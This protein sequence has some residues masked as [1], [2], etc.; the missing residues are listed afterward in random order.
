MTL[1]ED[2]PVD[3]SDRGRRPESSITAEVVSRSRGG[4]VALV[5]VLAVLTTVVAAV[6]LLGQADPAT[7]RATDDD[8]HTDH[9]HTE[10]AADELTSYHSSVEPPLPTAAPA[11]GFDPEVSVANHDG[12][13]VASVVDGVLMFTVAGGTV[14]QPGIEV[15]PGFEVR[16]LSNRGDRAALLRVETDSAGTVTG[17]AVMVAGRSVAAK[18]T[19]AIHH[20][21]GLVEP[22]AFST[23]GEALFVIDHQAGRAPG[24]YRVRSLNLVSGELDEMLGPSKQPIIEDMNGNGRRQIW[25]LTNNRLYT[26]YI[27]QTH[28]VH[29]SGASGTDGFVHILDLDE[30]WAFCLDLPPEFGQGSLSTTALT[31]GT[32]SLAVLDLN[33]G[34]SGQMA[35]ASLDDHQITDVVDLPVAFHQAMK[36][37]MVAAMADNGGSWD[38]QTVHLAT[39]GTGIAV[40]VGSGVVWFDRATMEPLADPVRFDRPLT[41]LSSVPGGEVLAW[42]YDTPDPALLRPPA[43]SLQ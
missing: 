40:G 14:D 19:P 21:D 41:G 35:Y 32:E 2:V 23:D 30:E 6:G 26:L 25:G 24:T 1:V 31:V 4:R 28:H 20:F 29:A 33:A 22:E 38:E 13:V 43:R 39:A 27:R 17:S 10:A 37:L 11:S 12:T 34:E 42:M 7:D 3:G 9:D 18:A 36:P 15:A 8:H 16:A 5:V